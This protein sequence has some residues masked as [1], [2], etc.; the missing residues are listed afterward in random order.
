M[1]QDFEKLLMKRIMF[2]ADYE[3]AL[4]EIEDKFTDT[5]VSMVEE[6]NRMKSKYSKKIRSML[7][8]YNGKIYDSSYVVQVPIV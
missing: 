8:E 1:N 2:I 4:D 7:D 6:V 3:D 5:K